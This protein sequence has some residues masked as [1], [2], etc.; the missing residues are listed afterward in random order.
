VL[1]GQTGRD[2]ALPLFAG[3]LPTLPII[4]Q[5][6][7]L[8]EGKRFASF[9]VSGTQ[10]ERRVLDAQVSFQAPIEGFFHAEAAPTLPGPDE[11]PAMSQLRYGGRADWGRFEKSCV[12]LRIIEPQRYLCEPSNQ[13]SLAFWIKLHERLPDDD[14]VHAAAW[15]ISATSGS[16]V[17]RSFGMSP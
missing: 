16:T 5:V 6:T 12:Q 2:T 3:A 14:A 4:Y 7:P 9:H 11:L 1:P 10:Q 15:P 8:Q 13:P 17:R